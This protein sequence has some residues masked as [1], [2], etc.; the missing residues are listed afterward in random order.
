MMRP[1]QLTMQAFGSYGKKTVIDFTVSNQNLFLITGDTGAGKTTIFD[2]IV[3][4]LYGEASS[5]SNRKDGAEL[6]S[7]FADYAVTP[8]VELAFSEVE[9]TYVVHRSPKHVR[10]L[11]RGSGVREENETVS[12][13]MPDGTEYTANTRDTDAKIAEIIGLTK[14]Q[15]MQV[16]MIAQG[17][18]MELL[19]AK[20][21]QKKEIFRKLFGTGL[22]DKMVKELAERRRRKQ[23][24]FAQIRT[25]CQ[26][27]VAH[28]E[29]SAD[30]ADAQQ[31]AP[32]KNSILSAD[33]LRITDMER[34]LAGLRTLCEKLTSRQKGAVVRTEAAG[35]ARDQARDAVQE[36][37]NLL[38][39]FADL[40]TAERTL[41]DCEARAA[42]V[43]KT[44]T[45]IEQIE[46]AYE[47]K[48]AYDR[49]E[50]AARTAR[51]TA[52]K[53]REQ[54]EA[55]PELATAW[56]RYDT[57]ERQARDKQE[58]ELEAYTK[59]SEQVA[60]AKQ[61]FAKL[62]AAQKTARQAKTDCWKAERAERAAQAAL[63]D[64]D[65]QERLWKQQEGTLAGVPALL[66]RWKNKSDTAERVA[67]DIATAEQAQK[68]VEKQK[69]VADRALNTYQKASHAYLEK[70][71][72]YNRKQ[73][74]FLDAQAGL[75]AREKLRPGEPCPVCGSVEHPQ[76]CAL[77][78]DAQ[79]LTREMIDELADVVEQ[80]NK[81]QT[82]FSSASKT[83]SDLLEEKQRQYENA[84]T[85]LR[86]QMA[87]AGL[88]MPDDMTPR[89]A[90]TRLAAWQEE[91]HA[92]EDKLRTDA[93]ALEQVQQSLKDAAAHKEELRE[94]AEQ[95]ASDLTARQ[96]ALVAAQTALAGLE[97]QKEYDSE[98][99]A[100]AVL[101][102]AEQAKKKTDTAYQ[103]AHQAAQTAK[104]A[105]ENAEIL[106]G[107]YQSELPAQ[108]DERD[109]RRAAYERSM[110]EK[111]LTE[112]VWQQVAAAHSKSEAALLRRESEACHRKKA[113]AEAA[114]ETAAKA[115]AGRQKPDLAALT[116][117]KQ[118][119]EAA[120]QMEKDALDRINQLCRTNRSAYDALAPK[121]EE[122]GRLAQEY[123]RIESLYKRLSGNVTGG[124]M[125]LETFVQRYYLQRILYAANMHFDEMSGG[126]FE[127]RMVGEEQAGAGK[128]RGLDLM[129]YS[130]VTGK[131]R[132][133]RTLSGGESFMAALS[134]ALGMADQIR[135]NTA[136]IH[137]DIMFIDEGFGSLDDH[138][139]SQAV[140]VLQRLAGGDKLIAI[141][142]HVSE[143]K[144]E[145]EDQLIVRKD[146]EGSR[147]QWKIS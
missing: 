79:N 60:R 54:Q 136:A 82:E 53:L 100:D 72:E 17:E 123:T 106:I 109:A 50:D 86:E 114:K 73:T 78:E 142:S 67:A 37:D 33:E 20:S 129:V 111:G 92:E 15:F 24:E 91:L 138:A 122:R 74:V 56:S 18:F 145:I 135:E 23:S 139:R 76:P 101:E 98:E 10:P 75:L 89:Q 115:I 96:N 19:R 32:L 81:E 66:E 62:R 36:A 104:T 16:A 126:Q 35:R 46:A 71:E 118:D 68:D 26:T 51:E 2:A 127:L 38:R 128:N 70:N 3:F 31:L 25:A 5:E 124:R 80:L 121:M 77:A 22:Y 147:V 57:A 85:R 90:K 52:E 141:I 4:A 103:S 83:A 30:D 44:E 49:Y 13:T 1:L 7:Q 28:I 112:L 131:E 9:E 21:D 94:E 11:R 110:T 144:Q 41:A 29:L 140:R 99:Q 55:I 137:L 125:D 120:W 48:A 45:L 42:E 6:Q 105:K 113:A 97:A 63:Q 39:S 84:L 69:T 117:A 95:Y 93:A 143:L 116:Q 47:I 40:E 61:V 132:E 119:A 12:L 65:A 134:L 87:D 14:S 27:E 43:Q 108:Q 64:F 8:F 107:R 59:V 133:V 88:D 102:A 146:E 58:K 34:L 130:N